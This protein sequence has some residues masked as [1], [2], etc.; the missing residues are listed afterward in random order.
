L[1]TGIIGIYSLFLYPETGIIPAIVGL[2][3]I[4]AGL[5]WQIRAFLY[6]GT[7]TFII[8]ACYQLII[9]SFTYPLLKWVIGLFIGLTF[10]WIAASFENRRSQIIT[11]LQDWNQSLTEWD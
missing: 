9:L 4:F 5:G 3:F 1:G 10:I 7:L 6:I 8:D 11:W 2:V